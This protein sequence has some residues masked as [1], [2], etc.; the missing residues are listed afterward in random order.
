M[1]AEPK[2]FRCVILPHHWSQDPEIK[3][4]FYFSGEMVSAEEAANENAFF[5]KNRPIKGFTFDPPF[6]LL[7]NELI[8]ADVEF[9]GDPFQQNYH[10]R[11]LEKVAP[12]T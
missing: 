7:D 6:P 1:I 10:L 12:P 5:K 8:A 3:E 11:N 4:K 9:M 2:S